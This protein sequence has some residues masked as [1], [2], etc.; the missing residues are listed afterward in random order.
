MIIGLD[1]LRKVAAEAVGEIDHIYLHWTAGH[2]E[3]C[4]DDYHI[5][6]GEHGEIHYMAYSLTERLAHTWNRNGNAIGIALCCAVGAS[7]DA[8]GHIDFGP[9]PPTPEQ[10]DAMAQVVAVLC[11]ELNLPIDIS[12]VMTHAEAA[13][14]DGYGPADTC[15][16]WDLWRLSDS[17][18]SG[19]LKDGGA[20]IRGKALYW[21]N[22]WR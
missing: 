14:I 2:Y 6:I 15:E 18:G 20:I 7:C 9:E 11:D 13:D 3:H 22:K 5:C 4:Y 17:P 16:R 19:A 10:I 1:Y 12:R 8:D 21:W